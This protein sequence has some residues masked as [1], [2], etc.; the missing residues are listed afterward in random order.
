[1]LQHKDWFSEFEGWGAKGAVTP[2]TLVDTWVGMLDD[3][4]VLFAAGNAPKDPWGNA[5][6]GVHV[7][8]QG[9]DLQQLIQKLT[10]G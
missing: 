7:T 3:Q 6:P 10:F 8:P 4:A 9:H 5:V 2:E 1:M